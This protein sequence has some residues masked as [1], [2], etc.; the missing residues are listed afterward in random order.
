MT[1]YQESF[2]RLVDPL[3]L[4]R[5]QEN[6]NI[7]NIKILW[8]ASIL[9]HFNSLELIPIHFNPFPYFVSNLKKK[10]NKETLES[11]QTIQFHLIVAKI[12]KSGIIFEKKFQVKPSIVQNHQLRHRLLDNLLA[13][14]F[15]RQC[16]YNF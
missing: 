1:R 6:S 11:I 3:T 4:D 12:T 7:K 5:K 10:H 2:S 15:S 9:R 16:F 13:K 8:F 14:V